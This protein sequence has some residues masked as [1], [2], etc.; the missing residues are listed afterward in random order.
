MIS[1]SARPDVR[2]NYEKTKDLYWEAREL[3]QLITARVK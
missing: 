1:F 3:Y 2:I